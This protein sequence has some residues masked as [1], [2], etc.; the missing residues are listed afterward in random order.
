MKNA[1]FLNGTIE[2]ALE[3]IQHDIAANSWR[4]N[5]GKF[6]LCV[7]RHQ[8]LDAMC[9]EKR[10]NYLYIAGTIARAEESADRGSSS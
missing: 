2:I 4:Q 1:S 9:Y 8:D 10:E 3:Q 7:S 5:R 6:T